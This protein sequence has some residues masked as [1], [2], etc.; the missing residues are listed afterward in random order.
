MK[1]IGAMVLI[2]SALSVAC[3][4]QDI[5]GKIIITKR[6]T[7]R[8]VTAPVSI[9]QRGTPVKLGNTADEDPIAFE[10]SRVVIYLEGIAAIP[11]RAATAPGTVEIEQ[12]N[13]QFLPDLAVVPVGTTVSFPNMDPI[14]HDVYS[15]SKAK[16]FDLGAYDKGQTR[17]IT[18]TKS[19]IVEVYCHLHPNM[20]ATIVVVANRYYARPDRE[21]EYRISNVPPGHYTLVAWHK[22]AGFFRKSIDVESDRAATA[23]FLIPLDV[24]GKEES[25]GGNAM[26]RGAEYR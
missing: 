22:T 23:D 3:P 2:L 5:S 18:F 15:L 20:S 6:L 26:Q 24:G 17:Q 11:S 9:Y 13:R 1:S 19:G 7:H 12:I 16:S 4:A 8:S 25:A 21:G 10:R 14:F